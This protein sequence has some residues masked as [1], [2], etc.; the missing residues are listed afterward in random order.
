MCAQ[1]VCEGCMCSLVDVSGVFF[2]QYLRR[3]LSEHLL[4]GLFK[5]CIIHPSGTSSEPQAPLGLAFVSQ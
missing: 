5:D 2:T 1:Y 4:P 3:L